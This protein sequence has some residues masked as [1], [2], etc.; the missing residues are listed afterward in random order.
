MEVWMKKG[1]KV[2]FIIGGAVLLAIIILISVSSSRRSTVAVQVSKVERKNVL[3]SKVTAS[4]QIRAKEFVNLQSE[5]SGIVTDL[6][7]RE[8]SNVKKGDILLKIDPIQT[9]ADQY[10]RRASYDAALADARAQ[11]YAVANAQANLLRDEASLT[12]ARAELT[13]AENDYSLAQSSFRRQQQLNEDGLIPR[14]DYERAQND[15][16]AAKSRLEVAK[17]KVS[18]YETQIRVSKNN[19]EQNKTSAAASRARA[20]ASSADLTR[21]NAELRKT[22]LYSPLDGVITQLNVEKGERAQPGIMSNPEATLM[23]IANLSV[24]QAELKV[25]ETD[26]VNLALGDRTEVK[27]D[28]LPDDVFQGEVTE[29]GNSPIST[30]TNTQEAKDFK[31]IITL[32]SPSP[33]LRPGMSCTGDITTDTRKDVLVIPIQ[34]LTIRDVEVDK[35]GKYHP[36]DLNKGAKTASAR[37]DADKKNIPKKELEGVFVIDKNSKIARFRVIK[38]GITGESEIEV[39]EN[40]KEG[41]E[42]VSGSFQTLRTLKDGAAV[43]IEKGGTSGSD[44]KKS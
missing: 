13:Q 2:W 33:K 14:D 41:D 9:A 15:L 26:I 35:D 11:E 29:I 22:T 34:A 28:A 31:V 7:V 6:P 37:A 23:T 1:K 16:K 40:L 5:I 42:I 36:P 32:K 21:A 43:K 44:A 20:E 25:D 30:S 19:I 4:G 17:A 38:T 3:T 27:V 12:S 24:I 18:Q 39:T 8:G 10:G